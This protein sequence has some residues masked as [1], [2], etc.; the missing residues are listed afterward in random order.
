MKAHL[1]NAAYAVLG[2]GSYSIAAALEGFPAAPAIYDMSTDASHPLAVGWQP[3]RIPE[4][5]CVTCA[6]IPCQ[7]REGPQS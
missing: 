7:I 6:A 3:T 5:D 1:A 2:R 4:R